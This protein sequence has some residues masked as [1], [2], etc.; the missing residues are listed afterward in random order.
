MVMTVDAITALIQAGLPGA[1]ESGFVVLRV[2][3]HDRLWC[4]MPYHPRQLRPG[5]TLSGPTMM[6]LADAAM[7]ACVL[8]H[9]GAEE[10]SVT[11]SLAINF[12]RRPEPSDLDACVELL[13]AG[14][15]SMTMDVRL[16]SGG[17]ARLVAQATG[18][19]ALPSSSTL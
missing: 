1:R 3:E 14:R 18:V 5:G 19:Y 6:A 4:R 2:D 15:R 7:Y 8:Y 12:L 9:A 17:D 13:K 10:M 11:Q 16:Y